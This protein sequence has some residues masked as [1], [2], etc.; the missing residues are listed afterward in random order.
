[1]FSVSHFYNRPAH[2]LRIF[3]RVLREQGVLGRSLQALS[4]VYSLGT[5]IRLRFE[6]AD[7]P[8]TADYRLA[9]C[10]GRLRTA[11][12]VAETG[13]QLDAVLPMKALWMPIGHFYLLKKCAGRMPP[14]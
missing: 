14:P 3:E 2:A 4:H 13:W 11:T 9:Y 8:P 7:S 10:L 1:M 5:G 12:A 6:F